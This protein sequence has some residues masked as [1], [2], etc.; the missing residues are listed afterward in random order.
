[1]YSVGDISLTSYRGI[2]TCS[3]GD[4]RNY[5]VSINKKSKY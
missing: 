4:G 5:S 2:R 1:M 3:S